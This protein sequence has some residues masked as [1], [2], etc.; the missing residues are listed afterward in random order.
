MEM[1]AKARRATYLALGGV[2]LAAVAAALL[3][4]TLAWPAPEWWLG[5]ALAAVVLV[6]AAEVV[7]L[8]LERRTAQ[9]EFEL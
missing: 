2:A 1:T 3:A 7:L 6:L 5:G 4:W 9:P 8:L